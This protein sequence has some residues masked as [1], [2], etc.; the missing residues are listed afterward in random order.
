TTISY[1]I[2]IV[3]DTAE[4]FNVLW[5]PAFLAVSSYGGTIRRAGTLFAGTVIGCLVAI[6][7]TIAVMP[8]ISE[9]PALALVLFAV[10][11]PSAYVAGGGPRFLYAGLE[12]VG[13]CGLC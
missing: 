2:G 12:I 1:L 5:H 11:V 8:N 3:A 4:L 10:T 9:L 7:A 6:V 13:R